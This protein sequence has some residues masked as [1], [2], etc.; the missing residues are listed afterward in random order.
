MTKVTVVEIEGYGFER[1]HHPRRDGDRQSDQQRGET[2][3]A[4]QRHDGTL[5]ATP[6]SIGKLRGADLIIAPG[7]GAAS[8]DELDA[9]LK[10]PSCRL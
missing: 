10:S 4:V 9:K 8:A 1:G 3:S 7:L 6:G 5:R 2:R